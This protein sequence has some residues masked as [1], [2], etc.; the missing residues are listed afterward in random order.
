METERGESQ[1]TL[2][3]RL[4]LFGFLLIVAG[5]IVIMASAFLSGDVSVSVGGLVFVGPIPVIVGAG[6]DAF[7]AIIL[8]AV[9]TVIGF[10]VFFWV[11]R[12]FREG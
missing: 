11:R 12:R 5:V 4:F 2:P 9:L 1:S 6:P 8:A 7:F 3:M 10:I